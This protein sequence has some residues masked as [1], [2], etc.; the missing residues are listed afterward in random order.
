MLGLY[1]HIPFC[2]TICTYCDFPKIIANDCKKEEYINHLINELNSYKDQLIDVKTVYIGGGTPNSLPINLLEKLLNALKPYLD[3]SI[4]NTIEINSELLTVEQVQ[5]FSRYN[6]NRIS[7]G[8]QTF[9]D[10][11][12]KIINRYHDYQTVINSINLLKKHN[13]N[14]INIDMIYGLPTQTINELE[15][16][17]NTLL[18]L[19]IKHISYYSLILEEKT[20]LEYQINNNII[21]PLEDEIVEEMALLIDNRLNNSRFIQYEISNYSLNTYESKHN[22]IY[23]NHDEY[24]GIGAKAC[25]FYNN[26]RYQNNFILHK[27]YEKYIDFEEIIN[28][29]E[30]KKE[31]MMLGLRK[32]KGVNLSEYFLKF[33]SKIEDD[34]DLSKLFKLDLIEIIDNHIRI[35]K[36]K[37]LLGNIVFE[38]FVG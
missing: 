23:W 4:E 37:I 3:N 7:I 31:Y 13:I 17:I 22:L 24:I 18:S 6:I 20:V 38:E 32:I 21:E 16:D 19:D 9:Y 27:Y 8:V 15:E 34:F 35:K 5:L 11:L 28:I 12:I 33:N 36:D 10:R 14:N 25:G 26:K 1:V 29:E 30:A 2:K